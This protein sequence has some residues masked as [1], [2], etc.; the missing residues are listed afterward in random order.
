[1]TLSR[2]NYYSTREA[3][4]RR[5]VRPEE[6]SQCEHEDSILVIPTQTGYCARCL[7]YQG[8]RPERQSFK[9]ARIALL[10]STLRY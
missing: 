9:E 5:G 8:V 3:S 6:T 7:I 10:G 2:D 1:M 4:T